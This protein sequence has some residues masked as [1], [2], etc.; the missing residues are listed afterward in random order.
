MDN[1]TNRLYS[2]EVEASVRATNHKAAKRLWRMLSSYEPFLDRM[3]IAAA[4]SDGRL[5]KGAVSPLEVIIFH[6]D[7]S[8]HNAMAI[9]RAVRTEIDGWGQPLT[10][11][12]TSEDKDIDGHFINYAYQ[13]PRRIYPSR[14]LDSFPLVGNFSV[15]GEAKVKMMEEWSGEEGARIVDY[16]RTRK[17]TSKGIMVRGS[18]RWKE[19]EV[20]HF[21][22]E[23]GVAYYSNEKSG[24]EQIQL[25]SFKPGPL[26]FVQTTIEMNVVTHVRSLVRS[27]NRSD[28][29]RFVLR[30]PNQTA[31]KL[32]YISNLGIATI[33]KSE[34]DTVKDCYLAFLRLYHESE[35]M[36][37]EGK[38]RIAF[39]AKEA[40]ERID[41][42]GTILNGALIKGGE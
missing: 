34:L 14:I 30:M 6:R 1:R 18:Q 27:G 19:R 2:K 31:S 42:L 24:A 40:R 26:R 29:W 11:Q 15:L 36:F 32:E 22:P 20:R 9:E 17:R 8:H 35:R 37:L 3:C 10:N 23:G 25:R 13:D 28:A 5:E 16:I 4:G 38:K 33:Q 41:A 12:L 39:D 21:D 7:M